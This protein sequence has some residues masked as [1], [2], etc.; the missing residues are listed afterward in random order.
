MNDQLIRLHA[1]LK[2][3]QLTQSRLCLRKVY[4]H[5]V[6]KVTYVAQITLKSLNTV[7]KIFRNLYF[8]Q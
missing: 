8:R 1:L 2:I 4:S 6:D 7:I 3:K 5:W